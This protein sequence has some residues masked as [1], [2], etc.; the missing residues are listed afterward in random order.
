[1]CNINL[2]CFQENRFLQTNYFKVRL[3]CM[4]YNNRK[5]NIVSR[6]NAFRTWC[7]RGLQGSRRH[8]PPFCVIAKPILTITIVEIV[9]L[10]KIKHKKKKATAGTFPDQKGIGVFFAGEEGWRA[11]VFLTWMAVATAVATPPPQPVKVTAVAVLRHN[12]QYLQMANKE[13]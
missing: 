3:E 6:G 9:P 13:K 7:D 4:K 8:F 1:M 12:R 5:T 2:L 10:N 11:L